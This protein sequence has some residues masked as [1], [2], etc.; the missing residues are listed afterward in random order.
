VGDEQTLRL[1]QQFGVDYGQGFFLGRPES[2]AESLSHDWSSQ[3]PG[4]S[5]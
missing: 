4:A 1:L 5:R 3:F 2:L